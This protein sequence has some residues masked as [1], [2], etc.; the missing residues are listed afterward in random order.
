MAL[1]RLSSRFKRSRATGISNLSNKTEK[2]FL[3]T[4]SITSPMIGK[5]RAIATLGDQSHRTAKA[6]A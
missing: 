1:G 2:R 6:I 4:C 3:F 5:L